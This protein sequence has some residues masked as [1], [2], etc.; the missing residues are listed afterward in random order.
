MFKNIETAALQAES[1]GPYPA[2]FICGRDHLKSLHTLNAKGFQ[3]NSQQGHGKLF[4]LLVIP[5]PQFF[6]LSLFIWCLYILR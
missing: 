4:I 1:Q 5:L 3:W 2:L 6:V